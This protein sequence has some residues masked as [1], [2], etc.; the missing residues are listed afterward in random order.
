MKARTLL[1]CT[2]VALIP[3]TALARA[4]VLIQIEEGDALDDPTPA[5]PVGGNS[6]TT[7]GEQRKLALDYAATTWG[8]RLDSEAP[9]T[10]GVASTALP[11]TGAASVLGA[12]ATTALYTNITGGGANPAYYYP[13][14]LA[15]KLAGR[16][17]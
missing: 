5:D 14:A 12:A 4:T 16:D 2:L 17:I 8:E 15:N 13:A 7:L 6:G 10:G 11:C 9:I 1:T 3:S